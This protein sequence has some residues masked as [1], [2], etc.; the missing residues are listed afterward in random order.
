MGVIGV[1]VVP[2]DGTVLVVLAG[3]S[4]TR[5]GKSV[6]VKAKAEGS[7]VVV[8]WHLYGPVLSLKNPCSIHTPLHSGDRMA[9]LS[10]GGLL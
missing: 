3:S 10:R 1:E 7:V 2:T 4:G 8:W 6:Y 9:V 5:G